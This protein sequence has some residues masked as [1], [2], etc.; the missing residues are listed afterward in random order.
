[1]W[2]WPVGHDAPLF[3][4]WADVARPD[5]SMGGPAGGSGAYAICALSDLCFGIVSERLGD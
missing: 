1:V 5:P 2:R 4:S 3:S